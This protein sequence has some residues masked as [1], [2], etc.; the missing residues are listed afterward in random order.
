MG[1]GAYKNHTPPKKVYLHPVKISRLKLFGLSLLTLLG[2]GGIG[3][4]IILFAHGITLPDLLA[5][6]LPWKQQLLH[7]SLFGIAAAV[8]AL[9]LV[10][11]DYFS[12]SRSFFQDFIKDLNP[13]FVEVVF[14]SLCAGVGEELLFRGGIQPWL[15]LWWTAILFIFL[16]GYLSIADVPSM[17]YGVLMVLVS[18]G[19]GYLMV[20]IGLFA[21]IAAHFWFDLVMFAYLKWGH[22]SKYIY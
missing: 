10:R 21:S 13:T 3:L 5:S 12:E 11:T 2:M 15:G 6:G 1:I 9:G 20:Y 22:K 4:L 8:I 16:H 7:G 18:A 17:L 14:Y 19:L